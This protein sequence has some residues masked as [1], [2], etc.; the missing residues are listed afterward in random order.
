MKN[1][2]IL[3]IVAVLLFVVGISTCFAIAVF[4]SK[5]DLEVRIERAGICNPLKPVEEKTLDISDKVEDKLQKY[6][7]DTDKSKGPGANELCDCVIGDYKLFVGE[8]EI[9]FNLDLGYVLYN[10][11][12]VDLSDEFYMYLTKITKDSDIKA[13]EDK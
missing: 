4:T 9:L 10:G 13:E 8:D 6:W 12:F 7:K 5:E 11:K 1:K 2:K 3:I